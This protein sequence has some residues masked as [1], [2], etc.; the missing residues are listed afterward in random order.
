MAKPDLGGPFVGPEIGDLDGNGRD[1]CRV[2]SSNSESGYG[3]GESLYS[4]QSIGD[5]EQYPAR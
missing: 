5:Y 2:S 3:S 4:M 1:E